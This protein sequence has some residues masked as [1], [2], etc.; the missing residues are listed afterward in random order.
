MKYLLSCWDVVATRVKE[1]KHT[2]LLIDYDGTLTPIVERPEL[3]NL[4]PE[5][6]ACLQKLAKNPH[7]TL[8]V[9][10]GRTME[11]LRERVGI[12]DIIYAGNHGLELGGPNINFVHPT[13]KETE[14]SLY[15]LCQDIRQAIA[16][17]K[18]ARIDNKGL[19]LSLHYRLVDESQVEELTKI[20]YRVTAPL[21]TSGKV[22]IT[23][24]KKVYEVRPAVDWDKG[25]AIELI[26]QKL[27]RKNKPLM[28]FLG[29]DVT[30][31]DGFRMVNEKGGISI[32]VGEETTESG[33]Q[34]FLHSPS[35]V[36]LFLKTLGN[37][38]N[39][40]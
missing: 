33:A 13:A 27:G 31:Y 24:G 25:R 21:S 10:S 30:D 12:N 19:T 7:L 4:S 11:D 37:A 2:L 23:E 8:G 28:L 16:D 38:F 3:A 26:A 35:E 40:Q 9:I 32:Y 15:S 22:R 14:P 5:T 29:D 36:H 34:Y 6:R 20:F 39:S 18:G 17:I 1:A